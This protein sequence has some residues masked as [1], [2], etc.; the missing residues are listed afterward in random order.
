MDQM[1]FLRAAKEG[2]RED[3][4]GAGAQMFFE[5]VGYAVRARNAF[6]WGREVADRDFLHQVLS[7]RGTNEPL[8]RWRRLFFEALE[9]EVR[10][11]ASA[12]REKASALASACAYDFFQ[13]EGATTWE[14]FGLLTALAVH[15]GR[16]ED[17]S[18][19]ENAMI[20]AVGLPAAQAFTPFWGTGDGN[21]AWTVVPL[22]DGAANGNGRGAVKVYL[23]TWDGLDDV[24]DKNA[25]VTAVS[26][27]TGAEPEA[28]AELRVW[29]QEAWRVVARAAVRD[30]KAFFEKVGCRAEFVLLVRIPKEPDRLVRVRTDGSVFPLT[31]DAESGPGPVAVA[32]DKACP[33]G[34]FR[35]DAEYRVCVH[36]SKGWKPLESERLATGAVG[37]RAAVDRLYRIEGAGISNRPFTVVQPADGGPATICKH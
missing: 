31:N 33:L 5:N 34:E 29:N 37:F 28:P 1:S 3:L 26:V 12:D 17:C 32:L 13:Y 18:N 36:T 8:Q 9:P 15:E 20:R 10:G 27:E 16:C 14:D 30:G 23:K 35:P 7:P 19:I 25:P 24:T 6:P 21:H 2:G 22:I 11:L 4:D